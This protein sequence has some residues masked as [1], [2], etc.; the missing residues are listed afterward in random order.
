MTSFVAEAPEDQKT[1][2]AHSMLLASALREGF[3]SIALLLEVLNYERETGRAHP[4]RG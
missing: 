1:M 3:H 2:V 4:Y